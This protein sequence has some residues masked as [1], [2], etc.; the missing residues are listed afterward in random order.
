MKRSRRLIRDDQID[1]L[2]DLSLHSGGNRLPMFAR[3]PA[4]V[5]AAFIGYPGSTG[6]GC[7]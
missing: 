6:L 5:Q 2:L 1:I 4:P 7:D 3:K